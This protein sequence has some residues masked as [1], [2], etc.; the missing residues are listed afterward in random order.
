M[1]CSSSQKLFREKEL[2]NR[3]PKPQRHSQWKRVLLGQICE[4]RI[5]DQLQPD[6][7]RYLPILYVSTESNKSNKALKVSDLV[8]RV[9][10]YQSARRTYI[11]IAMCL[12]LEIISDDSSHPVMSFVAAVLQKWIMQGRRLISV[13]NDWRTRDN[14]W[15]HQNSIILTWTSLMCWCLLP[16][17]LYLG[18]KTSIHCLD[19][20]HQ[21]YSS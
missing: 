21:L 11:Y 2:P 12:D 3:Q 19:F 20:S 13:C 6:C 10:S 18:V 4:S 1:C 15:T 8:A 16:E 17:Q 7:G 14:S 9:F 5:E